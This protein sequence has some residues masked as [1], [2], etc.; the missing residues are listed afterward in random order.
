MSLISDLN[1]PLPKDFKSKDKDEYLN[2]LVKSLQSMYEKVA[3]NVNGTIRNTSLVDSSQWTP[4]IFGT[5]VSGTTTYTQ[6]FGY[7]LRQG[8]VTDVWYDVM[9][10]A[11]TATGTLFV[12]LP[13]LVAKCA[14][15]VT[16]G[17]PFN[18]SVQPSDITFSPGV[19]FMVG[20]AMPDTYR[21]ELWQCGS[22]FHSVPLTVP[23][24]GHIMG[25]VRYIG[26]A[27]E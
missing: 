13:Y 24:S 26:V 2:E 25:W 14:G 17:A 15:A 8:I 18:G 1:L 16:G 21:L 12:E 3:Q 7:V 20:S 5:T 23:A 22:G 6:Q 4:E 27:D 11:T 9:W 10:S 19:A